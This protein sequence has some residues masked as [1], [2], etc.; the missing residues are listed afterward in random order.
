MRKPKHF[1]AF[2][3]NNANKKQLY[4]VLFKAW[5]SSAAASHLQKCTGAV[6]IVEGTAH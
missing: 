2:L 1:K 5:G 3:T 4:E 6:I